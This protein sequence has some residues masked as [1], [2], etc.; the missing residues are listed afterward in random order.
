M[1]GIYNTQSNSYVKN[2]AF[3]AGKKT[4]KKSRDNRNVK[5]I[6]ER[7]SSIGEMDTADKMEFIRQRKGE[8]VEKAKRGETEPS[9]PTGAASYTLKQWNKMMR[10]VDKAIDDMQ[11]RIREDEE[12]QEQKMEERRSS[13]VTDHMLSKLLDID[14]RQT[15]LK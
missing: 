10:S 13:A 15:I 8:I 7:I 12:K 11:E 9:I 4:G 1:S 6:A 5:D 14:E 3:S 2:S